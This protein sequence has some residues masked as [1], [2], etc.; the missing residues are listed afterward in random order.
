MIFRDFATTGDGQLTAVQLLAHLKQE[1]LTLAEAA[2][3]MKRYPQ[4]MIN[5]NVSHDGKLAFY[6]DAEVKRAIEEGKA[7]LPG[8]KRPRCG[9]RVGYGAARS[10]LW[11][12]GLDETLIQEDRPNRLRAWCERG[13]RKKRRFLGAAE[14]PFFY[15]PPQR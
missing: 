14:P 11:W 13:W 3:V 2:K 15:A 10:A 6:M 12:E 5:V 1:N 8:R 7:H 9:A 4:T